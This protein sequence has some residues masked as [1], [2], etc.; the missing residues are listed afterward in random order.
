M[1]MRHDRRGSVSLI[2][3]IMAN[4]MVLVT[5]MAIEVTYWSVNQ[6]ELQRIADAAAMAAATNYFNA[7]TPSSSAA[8]KAATTVAQ[9]NGILSANVTATELKSGSGIRNLSD[10]AFQVTVSRSINKTFSAMFANVKSSVVTIS[11]TAIAEI[12]LPQTKQ[13]CILAL[14]PASPSGTAQKSAVNGITMGGSTTIT[15]TSCSV[16]SNAQIDADAGGNIVITD[17]ATYSSVT[18]WVDSGDPVTKAFPGGITTLTGTVTDPYA[19]YAPLQNAFGNLSPG[20]GSSILASGSY[21]PGTYSSI[22]LSAY[23]TVV[24]LSPGTY[25]VNGDI[26]LSNTSTIQCTGCSGINGVTFITSGGLSISGG[27]NV[28]VFGPGVGAA[29]GIPGL[30]F[31]SKSQLSST[32]AYAGLATIGNGAA[33]PWGGLFYFPNGTIDLNGGTPSKETC[34]EY[35]AS[36]FNIYGSSTI[37]STC[38]GMG[39]PLFGSQPGPSAYVA[40]VE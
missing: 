24:N 15:A 19:N 17:A 39:L 16:V 37:K 9:L 38:S 5:A 6:V 31:A 29:Q 30:V 20:A 8:T 34:N 36:Q 12:V 21:P 1:S 25:Y 4:V 3:G 33:G 22:A 10:P 2:A 40:L 11:A 28:D 18:P 26:T 7:A 14:H 27:S 13:P 32:D 35:I 23:K